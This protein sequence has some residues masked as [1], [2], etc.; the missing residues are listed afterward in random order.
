MVQCWC[1]AAMSGWLGTLVPDA[2]VSSQGRMRRWQLECERAGG[3]CASRL[4]AIALRLPYARAMRC[5]ATLRLY[6]AA[7]P[8]EFSDIAG[9]AEHRYLGLLESGLQ[10]LVWQRAPGG[11]RFLT[12]GERC[13]TQSAFESLGQVLVP[14]L[15]AAG[16]QDALRV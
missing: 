6:T 2:Q 14:P 8:V 13:G 9:G 10:H 4:E 7:G 1:H 12:V 16:R 15:R 3:D 11:V 5:G